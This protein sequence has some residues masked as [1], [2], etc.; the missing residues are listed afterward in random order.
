MNEI[1]TSY[2]NPV[3]NRFLPLPRSA[4]EELEHEPNI[5]DFN[6][7]KEIG[8]G[9]YGKVYLASHKKTKVKYAIKAIDKLNI[10]NKQE[11]TCFNREVEIMYKLAHPNI[12]KLYAHFE[13]SK[14]CY[15]LTKYYP[16]G[17]AYDLLIKSGKK[18]NME[19]VSSILVDIIRAVYYLHN[20]VPKII[21]RDIKPENIL[22]DENN[23]AYLSDF[24]W[25]NYI[26]NGRRRNTIC[27]TPLYRPPEMANEIDYD[28]R[29]DIW[30]IGILLFELS[31]G[32]TPFKGNDIETVRQNI[33]ESNITWPNNIDPDIKDLCS[34]ILKTNPYQRPEIENILEHQFFKKYL[35]NK[36]YN[37]IKPKKLKN[38]IF[39]VSK[40]IPND[41]NNSEVNDKINIRYNRTQRH[42]CKVLNSYNFLNNKSDIKGNTDSKIYIG[43]KSDKKDIQKSNYYINKDNNPYIRRNLINSINNCEAEKNNNNNNHRINNKPN[44]YSKYTHRII[45]SNKHLNLNINNSQINPEINNNNSNNIKNNIK[46]YSSN[47]LSN[48]KTEENKSYNYKYA[49]QTFN[50][51]LII[52]NSNSLDKNN[53]NV[54]RF[55]NNNYISIIENKNKKD[56]SKNYKIIN[57]TNGNLQ[58]RLKKYY[59][60]KNNNNNYNNYNPKGKENYIYQNKKEIETKKEKAQQYS[61]INGSREKHIIQR[62]K[63][64]I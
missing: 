30:S 61:T 50:T 6:I 45:H 9:A 4:T 22:L 64:Y 32:K 35:K 20:M 18:P 23:N 44:K 8:T 36:E 34:K 33:G 38:K 3:K 27:G 19:L 5:S 2:L 62:K 21:H 51:R 47:I 29:I 17:N 39:V 52:K 10:E 1:N 58:E 40:D 14:Y 15:L 53:Y 16:N 57:S 26:I 59:T 55:K 24:G 60:I 12:V 11:K 63:L 48:M 42:S 37:L 31:T 49:N 28:E 54:N 56:L 41:N 13:D 46:L 25:S 43:Q 7:I